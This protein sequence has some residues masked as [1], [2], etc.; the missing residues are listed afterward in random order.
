[1]YLRLADLR[2]FEEI[3]LDFAEEPPELQMLIDL[4]LGH[5]MGRLETLDKKLAKDDMFWFG[6]D[7]G[8]QKGL[9]MGADKWRKYMRPC[10]AKIFGRWRETG[11]DVYFHTDGCIHEIIPDLIECGV[12]I[13]NPQFRSNGIDNLVR[14]CK[15]KVCCDLDLDRQLFPFVSPKD[16]DDHIRE[17]VMK[18]GSREGGLWIRAECGQDVPL[19]NM[20][21]IFTALTKYR[22]YWT[23]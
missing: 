13:I 9:A 12:Q 7:L 14:V 21:A 18:M 11:R 3:M 5:V 19:E 6:D 2:G 8:M 20:D 16:I 15:G 1:M 23:A 10:F 17:C 4:V 22:S